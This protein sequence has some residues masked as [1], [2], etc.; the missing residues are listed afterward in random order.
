FEAAKRRIGV[1]FG[2]LRVLTV[3]AYMKMV[4]IMDNLHTKVRGGE[5]SCISTSF[6]MSLVN[7]A[8]TLA[9]STYKRSA[10]LSTRIS[11]RSFRASALVSSDKLF[12][13]RDTPENNLSIP[14]EFTAENLKRAQEIMKRY[15]PQYKKAAAIPL[16]DLGQR[17][18][19]WTSI[20]V[21]NAVAKLL[22]MPPMRVYEVATFY[23]MFN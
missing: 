16:L 14:F 2:I 4:S 7:A 20:S 17:Q 11:Q 18:L 23:T 22:E 1:K 9:R 19:G 15:P 6:Q 21:M 3:L 5:K 13:H 12:T 8:R 10:A